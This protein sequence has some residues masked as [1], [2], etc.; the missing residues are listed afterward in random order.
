MSDKKREDED[1]CS[2]ISGCPPLLS[3]C[4]SLP[5]HPQPAD[6]NTSIFYTKNNVA[7]AQQSKIALFLLTLFYTHFP[8]AQHVTAFVHAVLHEA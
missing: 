7:N 3:G 5:P 4:G 2:S 1:C 6:A 8:A